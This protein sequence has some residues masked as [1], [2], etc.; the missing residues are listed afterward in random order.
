[1]PSSLPSLPPSRS[2]EASG[3]TTLPTMMLDDLDWVCCDGGPHVFAAHDLASS[4]QATDAEYAAACA[5]GDPLGLVPVGRGSGLVLGGDV[6]LSVWV[7]NGVFGSG[8]LVVPL[9]WQDEIS[10]A[11]LASLVGRVPAVSFADT[12]L[13]VSS[14]SSGFLLFAACD[15]GPG[16]VYSTASIPLPAGGYR[17]H[18][19]DAE[20]DGFLLRL[21]AL[22]RAETGSDI[23]A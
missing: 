18:T 19:G 16:W 1:M 14:A 11:T 21:H 4:W 5:A 3:T 6:P 9:V 13:V 20:V 22:Q 10:A 17:V 2:L 12:G 8:T 23:H 15:N 7:A